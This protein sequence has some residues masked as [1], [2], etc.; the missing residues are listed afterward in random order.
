MKSLLSIA[1]AVAFS[2]S[3][4]AALACGIDCVHKS[5]SSPEHSA[6]LH[7]PHKLQAEHAHNH[8]G[9]PI[10]H[11]GLRSCETHMES[12]AVVSPKRVV[13][14]DGASVPAELSPEF[15]QTAAPD[16]EAQCEPPW[17]FSSA[18]SK[19]RSLSLRI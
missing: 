11:T 1:L 4:W 8:P 12:P 14:M 2:A 18:L 15:L 13:R 7:S 19:P 9:E 3:N 6:S 5:Y 10:L 16:S 17:Q